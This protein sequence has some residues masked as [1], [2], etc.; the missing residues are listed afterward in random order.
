MI[1]MKR[2]LLIAGVAFTLGSCSVQQ[3]ADT[4]DL[5]NATTWVQNSGEYQALNLQAYFLGK[6]RLNQILKEDNGTKPKAIVLDIDETV[7]NNSPYE[8]FQVVHQKAFNPK[9]WAAWT[10]LAQAKP[11][12]GAVDFLNYAK[13]KGVSIFYISN[14][15]EAERAATLKNLKNTGFPDA[16]NAHLL[17]KTTTSS[18]VS[19]RQQ[20]AN[21]Y[22]IVLL[23][24]DNL[25][26]F[27]DLYYRKN[28][29]KTAVEK[30]MANPDVFGSKFI[31]L[32]N[33]MYGDWETSLYKNN[34]DKDLSNSQVKVRSL[35]P[36]KSKK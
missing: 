1:F 12:A 11:L 28:D 20:V 22:N 18:K 34:K 9:D 13:S 7:L 19:R 16:N 4:K 25:S 23:F 5:V 35:R 30:V 10:S 8:A 6:L 33:P 36:F 14:R 17:L 27:S 26:D 3:V 31:V 32:P 24:G 15:S 21:Q 29:G 2:F